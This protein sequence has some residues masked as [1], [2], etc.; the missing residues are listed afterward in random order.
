[1]TFAIQWDAIRRPAH[2]GLHALSGNGKEVAMV[3]HDDAEQRQV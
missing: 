3:E 2:F 1:M